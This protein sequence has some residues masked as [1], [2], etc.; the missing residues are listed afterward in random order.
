[1]NVELYKTNMKLHDILSMTPTQHLL[2]SR[3]FRVN[4]AIEVNEDAEIDKCFLVDRGHRN[5]KELHFVTSNGCIFIFNQN[6]MRFITAYMA[7]PN[8]VARL[9]EASNLI[10]PIS[11]LRRCTYYVDKGFNLI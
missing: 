6:T 9:Y 10:P 4:K 7:R 8:Q 3:L 2:D 1:M 5:G 11:A